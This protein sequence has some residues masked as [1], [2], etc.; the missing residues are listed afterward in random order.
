MALGACSPLAFS[1]LVPRQ[2]CGL[3]SVSACVSSWVSLPPN[4]EFSSASCSS[5]LPGLPHM[6]WRISL[7]GSMTS[8]LLCLGPALDPC[9]LLRAIY[10]RS[11]VSIRRH[12][13]R[14]LWAFYSL[15]HHGSL[16]TSSEAGW[17]VLCSHAQPPWMGK[18]YPTYLGTTHVLVGPRTAQPKVCMSCTWWELADGVHE[19]YDGF[20]W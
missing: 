6:A 1:M 10:I 4:S 5:E 3:L 19:A 7:M 18:A 11:Q 8:R 14:R 9:A 2:L 15:P 20:G 17:V 13:R 12:S 16:V